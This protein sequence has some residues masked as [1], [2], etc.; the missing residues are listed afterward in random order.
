MVEGM[1]V[2]VNVMLYLMIVMGPLP[3][4]Y[5]MLVHTV[6]KLCTFPQP[7]DTISVSSYLRFM[8]LLW[9]TNDNTV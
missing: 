9:R 8:Q 7:K 6:V 1:Y 5:I 4:L 2:V 3:A